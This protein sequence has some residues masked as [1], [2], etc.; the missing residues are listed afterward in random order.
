MLSFL[1]KSSIFTIIILVVFGFSS[2]TSAENEIGVQSEDIVVSLSPKT[3]EPY[4]D[5][6]ISLSSYST[7]LNK[8]TIVWKENGKS[9]LSG[10]GRTIYSFKTSGSGIKTTINISIR[11]SDSIISIDK[12]ITI[13]PSEVELLWESSEGYTPPFYKGKTLGI[14]GGLIKMVAIPSSSLISSGIGNM[15]YTWKNNGEINQSV[16][17]YNK[18][19]YIFKGDLF[20][21][22]NEISVAVSSVDGKYNAEKIL[23][24][25]SYDPEVIFYK[26]SPTDGVLYNEALIDNTFIEDSEFTLLAEPYFLPIS[27][28]QNYLKYTWKINGNYIETPTKKREI[29]LR[30]SSRG[31]YA[32]INLSVE[33]I[34]KLF[35]KVAGNLKISL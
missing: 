14:R 30:P 24:V 21:G 8:A 23:S 31:G 22:V 17:G 12:V 18:N 29:T 26:K 13:N 4:Q 25:P 33:N 16:S 20:E 6:S 10:I 1:K 3:P 32:T 28:E 15:S 34:N 19:Y 35:Q 9:V 27:G 5:V 2:I 7:D 11:P